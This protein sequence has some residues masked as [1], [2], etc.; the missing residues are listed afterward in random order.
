MPISRK[1]NWLLSLL[2]ILSVAFSFLV[3]YSTVAF[4]SCSAHID[5]GGGTSVGCHCIGSGL[6]NSTTRCVT[7]IC[8]GQPAMEQ[9]CCGGGGEN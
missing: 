1:T 8:Q 4:A 9:Y 7:C 2:G 3:L 6:C 5:C